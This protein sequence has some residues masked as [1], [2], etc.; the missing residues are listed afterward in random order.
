[1]LTEPRRWRL[2]TGEVWRVLHAVPVGDKGSDIDHVLIGPPGVFAINTKNHPGKR[3]WAQPTLITVD[4]HGTRYAEVTRA[5]ADRAGKLLT[6]AL[7]HPVSVVPVLS[8]VGASVVGGNHQP[9]GVT[10]VPVKKLVGWLVRLPVRYSPLH[11]EALYA[12]ARRSTTW[13]PPA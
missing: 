2:D 5:E 4:R 8:I 6:A 10:V 9:H 13:Q 1:M 11:V 3:V 12:A 7:R